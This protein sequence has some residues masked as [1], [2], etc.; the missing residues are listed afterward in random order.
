MSFF[1]TPTISP[2]IWHQ[3]GVQQFN[4]ILTLSTQIWRQIPQVKRAQ[5]H[6]ITPTWDANHKSQPTGTSDRSSYWYNL[7]PTTRH[8]MK[9]SHAGILSH[10]HY[11]FLH[12]HA[13]LCAQLCKTHSS[14]R[15]K[16]Y[17]LVNLTIAWYKDKIEFQ[18]NIYYSFPLPAN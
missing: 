13:C 18:V 8:V 12:I 5:S 3:L 6:K 10:L 2:I 1:L 4:L 14:K 9:M 11:L 7:W 17:K 15:F 16:N